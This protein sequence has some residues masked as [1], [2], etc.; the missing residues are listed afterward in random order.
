MDPTTLVIMIINLI[1]IAPSKAGTYT[2]VA[3]AIAG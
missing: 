2:L 3:L 1:L